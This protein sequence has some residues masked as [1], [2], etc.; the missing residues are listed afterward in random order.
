MIKLDHIDKISQEAQRKI[1]KYKSEI[2]NYTELEIMIDS[3]K[4]N[5]E[6]F[7]QFLINLDML[8]LKSVLCKKQIDVKRLL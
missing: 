5:S 3:L 1:I 4:N 7:Y 6:N 2:N 8:S